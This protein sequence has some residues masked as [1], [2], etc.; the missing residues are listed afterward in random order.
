M[1]RSRDRAEYGRVWWSNQR[2]DSLIKPDTQTSCMAFSRHGVDVLRDLP[3]S[4]YENIEDAETLI[5]DHEMAPETVSISSCAYPEGQELLLPGS[6]RLK[7][8][9]SAP[10][11]FLKCTSR[12]SYEYAFGRVFLLTSACQK[13]GERSSRSS[14]P[15]SV[16]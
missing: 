12:H 2:V 11:S 7:P 4:G 8:P 9:K 10:L 13:D 5:V 3:G 1:E 15:T 14:H 6:L 16:A